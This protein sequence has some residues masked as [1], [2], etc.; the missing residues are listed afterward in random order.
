MTTVLDQELCTYV[1]IDTFNQNVDYSAIPASLGINANSAIILNPEQYVVAIEKACIPL[2][3]LPLLNIAKLDLRVSVTYGSI[4]L[5]RDIKQ[6]FKSGTTDPNNKQVY[7]IIRVL[8]AL[9]KCTIEL[10]NEHSSD[11]YPLAP[12]VRFNSG[13]ELFSLLVPTQHILEQD[14]GLETGIRV[15]YTHDLYTLFKGLPFFRNVEPYQL[16]SPLAWC[17]QPF[18]TS[19]ISYPTITAGA[20]NNVNCFEI[21]S[22]HTTIGEWSDIDTLI[23]TTSM[24]I[25]PEYIVAFDDKTGKNQSMSIMTTL[26]LNASQILSS[27]SDLLYSPTNRRWIT[28]LGTSP[29][30]YIKID[31]WTRTKSG[32]LKMLEIGKGNHLGVTLVFKKIHV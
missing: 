23:I 9:N 4:T 32:D 3:E 18:T 29:M 22:T 20:K 17:L 30:N 25:Q 31:L 28:L 27:R 15:F 6:Y 14:F 1:N 7:E 2:D 19:V 24:P 13:S 21:M 16:S 26:S 8:D 12:I 5:T 10:Y 11:F